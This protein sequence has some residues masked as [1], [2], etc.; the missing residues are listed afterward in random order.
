MSIRDI[1]EAATSGPW[2]HDLE[3]TGWDEVFGPMIEG[4]A[5]TV[6]ATNFHDEEQAEADATFIAVFDPTHV[7]LME[8]LYEAFTHAI[9]HAD[10]DSDAPYLAHE[11][12]TDYRKEHGLT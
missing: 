4:P 5:H 10:E 11:A 2:S 12:L 6:A 7:A 1:I 9:E 3:A 8:D